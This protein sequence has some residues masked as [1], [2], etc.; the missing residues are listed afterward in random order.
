MVV[1]TKM[2]HK[3]Y[4]SGPVQNS[5]LYRV[6]VSDR[7]LTDLDPSFLRHELVGVAD[8]YVPRGQ[9]GVLLKVKVKAPEH[10]GGSEDVPAAIDCPRHTL[11]AVLGELSRR[12]WSRE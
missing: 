8:Q 7:S 4:T 3:T 2:A 10:G 9:G 5:H 6:E 11:D 1:K 12:G